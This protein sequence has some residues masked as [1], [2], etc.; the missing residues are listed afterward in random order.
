MFLI[1]SKIENK[2]D[3]EGTSPTPSVP[4][5]TNTI[6]FNEY[7]GCFRLTLCYN[8][9]AFQVPAAVVPALSGP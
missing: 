3:T 7:F 4:P 5:E 8:L 6:C 9:V 2:L 1:T